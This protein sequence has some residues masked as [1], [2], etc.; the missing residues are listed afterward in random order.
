MTL[1]PSGLYQSRLNSLAA[2]IYK[3]ASKLKSGKDNTI[4]PPE[5]DT[6]A[7]S[8]TSSSGAFQQNSYLDSK[9]SFS[10]HSFMSE[11]FP[12]Y[13]RKPLDYAVNSYNYNSNINKQ[14][15]VLIDFMHEHNRNFD[16]KI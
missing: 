3:S 5:Q 4:T 7:D 12:S 16:F 9:S 11:N 1:N 13:R 8:E 2:D 6:K 14:S 15:P 10:V